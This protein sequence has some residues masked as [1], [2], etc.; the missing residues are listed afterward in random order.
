ME[1]ISIGSALTFNSL[2]GLFWA[3]NDSWKKFIQKEGATKVTNTY[4]CVPHRICLF[5]VMIPFQYKMM[6]VHKKLLMSR[7]KY[8]FPFVDR[9][10]C[11]VTLIEDCQLSMKPH[12]YLKVYIL[13]H[14][15]LERLKV[16]KN[17]VYIYYFISGYIHK[18]SW[19]ST[20]WNLYHK[21][22]MKTVNI[23][24]MLMWSQNQQEVF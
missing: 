11:T 21:Q 8:S 23:S 13:F 22:I 1:W 19:I 2:R 16:T 24:T 3:M 6:V 7:L 4:H 5:V 20:I 14:Y 9:W 12:S 17:L 18:V 10:L 15:S